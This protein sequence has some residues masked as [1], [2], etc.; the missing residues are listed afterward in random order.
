MKRR[1]LLGTLLSTAILAGIALGSMNAAAEEVKTLHVAWTADM[2]TMDVHKTSSNYCIPL[3]IFDRLFEIQL[4]DDGT[5]ELVNSLV[6]DYTISEDGLTYDFTLRDGVKF[7]DGTPLT[8]KDVEFTFTRMLA[9]DDSVQTDFAAAIAGADELMEGTADTLAGFEVKDDLHFTVTLSEPF[10]GYI[11]QLAT[12]SCSI[13]SQKNV[14]EAGDDFGLDPAK[15]IGSGPYVLTE[16]NLN[17]SLVLEANPEYWGEQPS[18]QRV[19]IEIIPEADTRSQKF[20]SGEID[21]LD[22]DSIDSAVVDSIYRT[23]YADQI[24]PANR[25]AITYLALNENVEPLNDV[26]VRQAIQMA[27][28]RQDILDY[29]YSGDGSVEDGIFPHGLIGFCEDNQGWLQYDPD[30]A[31]ELLAEAG[32]ADGFE[33]ELA[34][35]NSASPSVLNV[36]QVIAQ[37]L[38]EVGITAT[39]KPYDEASWLDLRKSGDMTSFVATWTA[40]YNDPD[41]FIYTFFGGEDKTKIRSLNY[42]DTEV[43]ER[44]VDARA[45]VDDNERLAEYAALENKIVKED[46]A[47]VPLFSRTHLFVVNTDTV[48][49]FTPHW[50]GYSDFSFV[51]VTM[52]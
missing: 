46:A 22:C 25:L 52:K 24:V 30:G 2:Q 36:L 39:I 43:M 16:W 34:S 7:S 12:A 19:E 1:R 8:A 50:A 17:D 51:G 38:E 44:V 32:Y 37:N 29:I 45:I 33:M 27:I 47:W 31:R 15:T 49:H 5:T 11:Y 41:N 18:A 42:P 9:L 35:D 14:E 13:M 40:D 6:E 4:N 23:M 48:E 10:A 21:I 26:R 3:C 28:N 20:Q